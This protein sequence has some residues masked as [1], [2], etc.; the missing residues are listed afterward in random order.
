M[1]S[2]IDAPVLLSRF[3]VGSSARTIAGRP[4]EG[5]G[6]RNPLPLPAG[7]LR[8]LEV[9]A[10]GQAYPVECLIRESVPLGRGDAGVKQPVGD[11]LPHR[12]M[13][14]QEELLEDEPNLLGPEQ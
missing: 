5:A 2:M 12:G 6:D 13:F 9:G 7:D 8:W 4:D 10:M 14:G 11:V 3:P 1:S